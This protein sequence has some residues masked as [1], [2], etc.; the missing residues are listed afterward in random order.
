[1]LQF[2]RNFAIR[3]RKS[4]AHRRASYPVIEPQRIPSTSIRVLYCHLRQSIM[5]S[6]PASSMARPRTAMSSVRADSVRPDQGMDDMGDWICAV[7]QSGGEWF[8]GDGGSGVL[9]TRVLTGR[10]G[11]GQD[12]GIASID[13][14]SG[15][16]CHCP[17]QVGGDK[18]ADDI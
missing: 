17:I 10:P 14:Q 8:L 9:F 16:V 5:A 12:V 11:L 2:D 1:M 13:L 15:T 6:R 7:F 4:L 18:V 3:Y